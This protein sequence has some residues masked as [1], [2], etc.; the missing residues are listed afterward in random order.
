M[1]MRN[2]Y[3]N[4]QCSCLYMNETNTIRNLVEQKF[5]PMRNKSNG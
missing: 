3:T 5:F 1:N 2:D 4:D